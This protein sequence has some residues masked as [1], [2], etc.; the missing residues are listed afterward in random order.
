MANKNDFVVYCLEVY[1]ANKGFDSEQVL[2]LF[3]KHKVYDYILSNLNDLPNCDR[4][5][6]IDD[7][8]KFIYHQILSRLPELGYKDEE[9]HCV[10]P[11]EYDVPID[12][13]YDNY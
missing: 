10:R 8:D 13:V 12:A 2:T 1:K 6:I 5:Y 4:Q 11:N 9:G 3:K 7:I